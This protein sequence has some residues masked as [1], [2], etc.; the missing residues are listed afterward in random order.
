MVFELNYV[1]ERD[2]DLL[3]IEEF[4]VNKNF[5][6]LFLDKI[7]IKDYDVL[8]V[9]HSIMHPTL[10]E[11][12]IVIVLKVDTLKHAILIEN[13]IDALAMKEQY[14]R[15]NKRGQEGVT[16]NDYDSFSVFIVGPDKYISNNHEAK[17]YD[18]KL[19]YEDMIECF[20]ESPTIRSKYKLT[21]LQNAISKQDKGYTPVA[22]E[23]VTEFWHKYYAYKRQVFPHLKLNEVKGSRG[24]QA[25]WSRFQT[26]YSNVSIYHKS[27]VGCVDLTLHGVDESVKDLRL[28]LNTIIDDDMMILKTSKSLSIRLTVPKIHFNRDFSQQVENLHLA[29]KAV[30]RLYFL[31]SETSFFEI[32]SLS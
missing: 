22:D 30:E 4:V 29:M 24:S 3:I 15:Y 32:I 20:R 21:L 18:Q 7:D 14:S 28:K 2:I 8:T 19:S 23:K 16:N 25:R 17:K 13:K 27:N 6:R 26:D 11:S 12:D 1:T 31:S 9:S 10:G 5:A